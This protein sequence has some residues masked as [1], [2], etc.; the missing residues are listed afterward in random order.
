MEANLP[1]GGFL[2]TEETDHR[3]DQPT[4]PCEAP[5]CTPGL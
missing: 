3:S 4:T 5:R 2:P 1:S